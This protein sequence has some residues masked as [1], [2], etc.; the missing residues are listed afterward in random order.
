MSCII[1]KCMNL[2]WN[3]KCTLIHILRKVV[4]FGHMTC[5]NTWIIMWIIA[6]RNKQ[7]LGWN[8]HVCAF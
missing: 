5:R 2:C 7:Q 4:P 1:Y 6:K 3:T 8:L